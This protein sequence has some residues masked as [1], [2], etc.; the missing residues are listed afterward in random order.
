MN[1][2]NLFQK[3]CI[4]TSSILDFWA[5]RPETRPYHVQVKSFRS[6]WEYISKEVE[7]GAI[8]VPKIV[9][10]EIQ[11]ENSELKDWMDKHKK[12][13]RDHDYC[14]N[15]LAKINNK[16]PIYTEERGSLADAIVISIAKADDLTVIT[17][18]KYVSQHSKVRPQIPN[19][20]SEF[21]VRWLRL[22]DFFKEVGL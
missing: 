4:D 19:V 11:P 6:I 3:Y 16:Y 14:L 2:S 9:A 20:C 21:S 17:S 15:E 10:D 5:T 7:K 13:F 1:Q 8:I 22:P 12:Y 18:E